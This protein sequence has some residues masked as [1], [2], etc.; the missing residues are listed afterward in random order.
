MARDVLVP[1]EMDR[2]RREIERRK[3]VRSTPSPE[4][5]QAKLDSMTG[6]VRDLQNEV[7]A[8]IKRPNVLPWRPK[9]TDANEK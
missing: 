1:A 5:I 9:S 7:E 8:L 3:A 2:K 4:A 6:A